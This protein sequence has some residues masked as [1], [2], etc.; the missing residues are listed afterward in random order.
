MKATANYNLSLYEVN[1]MANLADGYNDSMTKIDAAMNAYS[2]KADGFGVLVEKE[3]ARATATENA[4]TEKVDALSTKLD[5]ETGKTVPIARG[6]TG[7]TSSEGARAALGAAYTD[8][9]GKITSDNEQYTRVETSGG[10]IAATAKG[11]QT[12]SGFV[13]YDAAG[14]TGA[15]LLCVGDSFLQ[16]YNPDGNVTNWGMLLGKMLGISSANTKINAYGGTGFSNTVS[17]NSFST[18]VDDAHN[19]G[20]NPSIIVIGGGINDYQVET[21]QLKT[22]AQ[23]VV[24]KCLTYWPNA[25]IYIF[26]M[27]MGCAYYQLNTSTKENAICQG[28]IDAGN[29]TA[30]EGKVHVCHSC[31][32]WNYDYPERVASDNIH[33][34]A[35]GQRVIAKSMLSAM[36]GGN[37]TVDSFYYYDTKFVLYRVGAV[38]TVTVNE[39]NAPNKG[40]AVVT[41]PQRYQNS[42]ICAAGTTDQG[43]YCS[44]SVNKGAVTALTGTT[45]GYVQFSY[46]INSER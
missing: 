45:R 17:G 34:N 15:T 16:G 5:T 3:T 40:D 19:E 11:I 18:L 38:C 28:A 2:E 13:P 33:P 4:I 35:T 31:W 37:P 26:P 1:D 10:F 44:V 14:Q 23:S 39:W 42:F 41:L 29:G 9:N 20:F 22:A 21:T 27:L 25:D 24:Q 36:T 46:P 12:T 7:A 32:T 6:G 30:N 43:A 8:A